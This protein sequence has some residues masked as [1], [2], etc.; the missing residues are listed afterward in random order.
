MKQSRLGQKQFAL[1]QIKFDLSRSNRVWDKNSL[2]CHKSSLI[3]HEAILFEMKT[4]FSAF[5]AAVS[6]G[7]PL[8]LPARQG[9]VESRRFSEGRIGL[10]RP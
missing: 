10:L 4:I 1:P 5:E 6:T 9:S 3:C 7:K 8:I 2:L